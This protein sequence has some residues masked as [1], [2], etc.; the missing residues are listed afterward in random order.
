M[1][2]SVFFMPVSVV[3]NSLDQNRVLMMAHE[4]APPE[5]G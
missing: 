4:K 3:V 5:I 2:W 1:L